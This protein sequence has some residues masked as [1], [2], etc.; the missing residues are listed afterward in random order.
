[1]IRIPTSRVF[2][3]FYALLTGCNCQQSAPIFLPA[4]LIG[5]VEVVETCPTSRVENCESEILKQ[6][7]KEPGQGGISS[8]VLLRVTEDVAVYRLWNGPHA[9]LNDYGGTNR[10]GAWWSAD[11]PSGKGGDYRRNNA[12][13]K[14]WNDLTWEVKCT[15]KKGTTIAVGPTQSAN[16]KDG[17]SFPANPTLQIYV[18]NVAS[19]FASCPKVASENA[20]ERDFEADQNEL[21]LEKKSETIAPTISDQSQAETLPKPRSKRHKNKP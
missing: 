6:A 17:D 19:R 16:C 11:K 10:I 20:A 13:C 21:L 4:A 14:E 15:L 8:G 2:L 1:M 12:I 5:K 7:I 18:D 3:L 9:K